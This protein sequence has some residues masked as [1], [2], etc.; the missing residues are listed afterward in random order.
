MFEL[1]QDIS[2]YH[3][4][5]VRLITD[6]DFNSKTSFHFAKQ[7]TAEQFL[8]LIESAD[9]PEILAKLFREAV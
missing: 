3:M 7:E 2:Y 4:F 5:C 9:D 8:K 1:F 6:R